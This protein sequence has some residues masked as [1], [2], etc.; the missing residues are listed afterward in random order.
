MRFNGTRAAVLA[1]S[2]LGSMALVTAASASDCQ[3]SRPRPVVRYAPPAQVCSTACLSEAEWAACPTKSWWA[4]SKDHALR[5][6]R[7]Y[8]RCGTVCRP[9]GSP[10]MGYLTS[11]GRWVTFRF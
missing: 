7:F 9:A 5:T 11:G 10:R 8:A 2:V 6:P 4:D 1:L 3:C